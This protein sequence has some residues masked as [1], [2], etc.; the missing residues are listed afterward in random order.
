MFRHLIP[1]YHQAL[2]LIE[3]VT[4][5][6]FAGIE[7]LLWV[8]LP[9]SFGY[10]TEGE[11]APSPRLPVFFRVQMNFNAEIR[12]V[13]HP[14]QQSHCL[15]TPW[16]QAIAANK[17]FPLPPGHAVASAKA[18]ACRFLPEVFF[19]RAAFSSLVG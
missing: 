5:A 4:S 6:D 3:E 15:P 19:K 8:L 10:V 1:R 9:V 14:G 16:A 7:F 17:P 13:F 18:D 11:L 12:A 2:G